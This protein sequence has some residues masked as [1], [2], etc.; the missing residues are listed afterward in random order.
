MRKKEKNGFVIKINNND[1][2]VAITPNGGFGPTI[3][4][5]QKVISNG[6]FGASRGT[7]GIVKKIDEPFSK[8]RT[9]DIICVLFN[10]HNFPNNM[11][12]KDLEL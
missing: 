2:I 11:K 3:N 7:K 9:D 5:G 1:E 4:V 12:F 6:R 10:S 8:G